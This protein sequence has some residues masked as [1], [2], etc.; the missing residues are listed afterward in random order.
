MRM[1]GWLRG[2]LLHRLPLAVITIVAGSLLSA[3][4]VRY[5]PGF[6]TDERLL[7][8]RLS[9]ESRNAIRKE[10][11][12]EHAVV[13]YYVGT[14]GRAL[15]G[16]L[17]TSRSMNRPVRELVAERSGVTIVLLTKALGLVWFITLLLTYSSSASP[18]AARME[19]PVSLLNGALLSVPAAVIA[20]LC[21]LLNQPACVALAVILFPKV[22][23]YAATLIAN[24]REMPHVLMAHAKGL[25]TSRV[26]FW[27]VLPAA[28]REL[29]AIAGISI[30]LAIGAAIPVEALCSIP[31]LGQ[32]AW[33]SAL[34]R[35]LPVLVT[36]ATLIVVCVVLANSGADVVTG[37]KEQAA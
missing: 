3:T 23:R 31:G 2:L 16:D 25:S 4:L 27:H 15:H 8:E 19:A 21:V 11:S 20:L 36:V 22:H 12:A 10:V 29:L 33:Q 26:F 13:K 1:P 34:G 18:R 5:A 7:D 17:G 14:L 37:V 35:D 24:T 9:D 32:L 6:A 30:S 28:R